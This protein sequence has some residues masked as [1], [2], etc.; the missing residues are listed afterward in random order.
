MPA[1]PTGH[2]SRPAPPP[3]FDLGRLRNLRHR[4][5]DPSGGPVVTY[6]GWPLYSYRG[7]A[8]PGQTKGQGVMGSNSQGVEGAWYVATPSLAAASSSNSGY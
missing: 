1:P 8:F 4:P 3:G 2:P 6:N 7:D 5:R